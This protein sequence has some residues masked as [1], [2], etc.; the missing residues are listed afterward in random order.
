MIRNMLHFDG[1]KR[2][3]SGRVE[4]LEPT[5]ILAWELDISQRGSFRREDRMCGL[6]RECVKVLSLHPIRPCSRQCGVPEKCWPP[7]QAEQG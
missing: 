6:L 1:V 2:K 7:R 4:R 5:L 3:A